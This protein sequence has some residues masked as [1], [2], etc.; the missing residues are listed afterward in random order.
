MDDVGAAAGSP[1]AAAERI[2]LEVLQARTVVSRARL[3]HGEDSEEYGRAIAGWEP[4]GGVVRSLAERRGVSPEEIELWRVPA[5]ELVAAARDAGLSLPN[6]GGGAGSD[7]GETRRRAARE[8]L[9][10]VDRGPLPEW[11]PEPP[12]ETSGG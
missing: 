1:R 8:G 4:W 11:S 3:L 7:A 9:G 10:L 6:A 2:R 12:G 5:L